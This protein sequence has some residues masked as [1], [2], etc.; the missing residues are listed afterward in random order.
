MHGPSLYGGSAAFMTDFRNLLL[1]GR[2]NTALRMALAVRQINV[3]RMVS[4][5]DPHD[6]Q[7]RGKVWQEAHQGERSWR[8]T[9]D[10]HDVRPSDPLIFAAISTVLIVVE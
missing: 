9:N 7:L 4:F 6:G 3:L 2:R 1:R 5:S 8:L 10:L